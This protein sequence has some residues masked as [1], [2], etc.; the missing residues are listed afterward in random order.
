MNGP[1][2]VHEFVRQASQMKRWA[3]SVL[4]TLS[5]RPCRSARG[6]R[7]FV[8][9]VLQARS[10]PYNLPCC[11]LDDHKGLARAV[12]PGQGLGRVHQALRKGSARW[13]YISVRF[14]VKSG[15]RTERSCAGHVQR[16]VN[17]SGRGRA[18]ERAQGF[19]TR[20]NKR[21]QWPPTHPRPRWFR[22]TIQ[23]ISAKARQ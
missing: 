3:G 7:N 5:P 18:T 13:G 21:R 10:R 8:V 6:W 4:W 19:D 20:R 9:A 14:C 22:A 16:R 2:Q 15:G 23:I 1:T 11:T 17:P 12:Y